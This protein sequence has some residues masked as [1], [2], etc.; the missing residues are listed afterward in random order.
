MLNKPD[1][2]VVYDGNGKFAG[3]LPCCLSLLPFYSGR[4]CKSLIPLIRLTDCSALYKTPFNGLL[5][6]LSH[7]FSRYLHE[8]IVLKALYQSCNSNALHVYWAC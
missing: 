4:H 1:A 6:T 3:A 5:Y 2:K 7:H 8:S